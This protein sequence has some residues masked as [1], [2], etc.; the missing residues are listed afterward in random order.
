MKRTLLFGLWA[1]VVL[2]FLGCRKDKTPGFDLGKN[3][4][5]TMV[6]GDSREYYIH[7][8]QNYDPKDPPAVVY[9]L[10][11]TSGDGLKFYNIS[12]WK[13]LGEEENIITVFPS[14]W[15]YC[16][17]DEGDTVETTKWHSYPGGFEFCVGETPRD[18]VAF[19]RQVHSEIKEKFTIDDAHCYLAGFSNGGQMAARCAVE[20]SDI[21]AA[22]V[23][24]AG[25]FSRDTT[26]VPMNQIPVWFMVGNLDQHF[27]NDS[28]TNVPMGSF[29]SLL[30]TTGF[31]EKTIHSHQTTFGFDAPHQTT[32][33]TLDALTATYAATTP[34]PPREF[35]FTLIYGLDHSYAKDAEH[36][37]EGVT[38]QWAW[39][40]GYVR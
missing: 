34:S 33:D 10:H 2:G 40:S 35:R 31:A 32:G 4:F 13:E 12:G 15:H 8:P 38:A 5:T 3:R 17:I 6:D 14:S 26:C 36:P 30:Q 37:N 20:M 21:F 29:E 11:G 7:V 22:V 25:T 28:V 24:A 16:V 27:L 19:L 18:D 1:V 23:E 39:M 9:M